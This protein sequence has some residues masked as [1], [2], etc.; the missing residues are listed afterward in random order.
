MIVDP[1]EETYPFAGNTEF[2]D[3]AGSRGCS[4]RGRRACATPIS[5]GSPRIARRSAAICARAAGA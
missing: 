4:R 5:R 1:I 2:L 3:P